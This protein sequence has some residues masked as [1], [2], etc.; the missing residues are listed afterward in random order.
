MNI[1]VSLIDF[2][3]EL[4]NTIPSKK[5]ISKKQDELEQEAYKIMRTRYP[6]NID[7]DSVHTEDNTHNSNTPS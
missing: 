5:D 7:S 2:F 3:K 4:V 6:K 1:P